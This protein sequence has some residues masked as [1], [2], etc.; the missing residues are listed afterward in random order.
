MSVINYQLTIKIL[1]MWMLCLVF[2]S[3]YV[4]T[5]PVMMWYKNYNTG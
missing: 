5:F 1:L 4:Y 3:Q 2:L